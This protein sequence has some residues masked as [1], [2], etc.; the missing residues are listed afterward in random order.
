MPAP[1][2]LKHYHIGAADMTAPT[3]APA[4]YLV[5]TPIGNLRDVTLRA[6]ETLAAADFVYCEDTRVTVKLLERYGIR[7]HLRACHEHNEQE[8]AGH[9]VADIA[10]GKSVALV[11][12]AG[13]PLISDPGY[14]LVNAA[15]SAGLQVV[16]IPG[17]SATLTALQVSGLATDQFLFLGFL[18]QKQKA[19]LDALRDHIAATATLIAYESPHRLVAS[20]QDIASVYGNRAVVMARELTKLHEE[21]LRGNAATLAATLSARE[22][23]KGECVLV[24]TGATE[25]ETQLDEA[26]ITRILKDAAAS[27]P[28]SKAAAQASRLTGLPRDEAFKRIL[29]LKDK[30]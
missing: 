6:L 22:A 10:A 7:N 15:V 8:L 11:S 1:D 19:R 21:V 4:L 14:R 13:L 30:K 26:A 18:P 2:G 20:L 9:I 29:T 28:A 5:A 25:T 16:S 12:D 3:L 24:I 17:A 23:I 27:L